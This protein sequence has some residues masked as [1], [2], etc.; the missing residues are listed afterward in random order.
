MALSSVLKAQITTAAFT[1]HYSYLDRSNAPFLGS[2]TPLSM[3]TPNYD[4]FH[5]EQNNDDD[6]NNAEFYRD[7]DQAKQEKLGGSN[8]RAETNDVSDKEF[9]DDLQRAKQEKLGGSI[10]PEQARESAAQAESD[11]LQAMRE[12]KAEFQKAKEELG[13]DG[14]VDLFLDR[15]REEEDEIREE[16]EDNKNE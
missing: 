11:F 15:I 3:V 4:D 16:E 2:P 7:L 1:Q 6:D 12:T 9:Y 8:S 5:E 13:S 10:P 14:A